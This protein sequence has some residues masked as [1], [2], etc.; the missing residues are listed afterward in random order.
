MLLQIDSLN[1]PSV[2]YPVPGASRHRGRVP[3]KAPKHRHNRIKRNAVA[4]ACFKTL[5][6]LKNRM[7]H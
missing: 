5:L 4:S 6:M 7:L 3:I 2:S 1:F